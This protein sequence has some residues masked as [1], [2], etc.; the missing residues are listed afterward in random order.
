MVEKML[1]V[2]ALTRDNMK[3]PITLADKHDLTTIASVDWEATDLELVCEYVMIN[4]SVAR[5][6]ESMNP[7]CIR[8]PFTT[9][10]L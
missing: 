8:I 6:L 7:V 4:D 5:A 2:G 10:S 9:F 3:V 1:P